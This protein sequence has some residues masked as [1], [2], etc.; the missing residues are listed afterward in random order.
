MEKFLP[1][2]LSCSPQHVKQ[3][4]QPGTD[5]YRC[6]LALLVPVKV[7]CPEMFRSFSVK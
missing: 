7:R 5:R 4:F 6:L 1:V 3:H 2:C